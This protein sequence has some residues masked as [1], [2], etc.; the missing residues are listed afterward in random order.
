MGQMFLC[1]PK[2]AQS[3]KKYVLY[4][5][6]VNS[7]M[8]SFCVALLCVLED[9]DIFRMLHLFQTCKGRTDQMTY[10]NEKVDF[11]P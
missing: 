6:K 1:V 7:N 9:G 5:P 11:W 3:S 10:E 8:Y 4:N 2:C